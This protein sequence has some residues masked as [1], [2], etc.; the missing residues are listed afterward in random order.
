[1]GGKTTESGGSAN[2]GM[3]RKRSWIILPRSSDADGC[4][5][6]RVLAVQVHRRRPKALKRPGRNPAVTVQDQV[7]GHRLES[8]WSFAREHD[9]S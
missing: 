9:I 1:M 4:W 7:W 5:Q 2:Q 3:H 8:G 6:V